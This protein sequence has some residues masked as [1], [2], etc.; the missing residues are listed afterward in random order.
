MSLDPSRQWLAAGITGLARQREWDAMVT[1]SAPGAGGDEVEFVVLPDGALV[2]EA[3]TSQVDPALLADA[4]AGAVEPP[5]RALGV[6]RPELWV[7]G[8]LALEVVSIGRDVR[9]DSVEV[10]RDE[11]GAR[12]R[13]DGLPSL[14]AMPEL[15]RLGEARAQSYVVRAQRLA[16]QHFEVEVEPL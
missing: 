10:V 9:G 12:I 13:I 15:E 1:V 16:G 4:L 5:Y 8:A 11:A 14:D 7:V 3:T 2:V 6:R